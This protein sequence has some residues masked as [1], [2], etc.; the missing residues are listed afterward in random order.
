MP[1]AASEY[2][3]DTAPSVPH[4][5]KTHSHLVAHS[6]KLI[7]EAYVEHE[8]AKNLLTDLKGLDPEEAEF[9]ARMKVLME[10]VRHHVKEEEEE[11][12]PRARKEVPEVELEAMGDE[13]VVFKETRALA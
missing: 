12:L 9:N 4:V 7:E 3:N 8:G 5:C 6:L 2:T 11:I 1:S 10:Q 13:M